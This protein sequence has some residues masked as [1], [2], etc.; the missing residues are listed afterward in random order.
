MAAFVDRLASVEDAALTETQ[1]LEMQIK[2]LNQQSIDLTGSTEH[3]GVYKVS[4]V[5]GFKGY[6]R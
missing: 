2:S 5:K 1:R 6:A 4:P 3:E